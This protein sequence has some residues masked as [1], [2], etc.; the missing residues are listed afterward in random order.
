M[1]PTPTESTASERRRSSKRY[2][3]RHNLM[4]G[5][6]S[7]MTT[8]SSSRTSTPAR[9]RN[10]TPHRNRRGRRSAASLVSPV[11]IHLDTQLVLQSPSLIHNSPPP[12]YE[13][14]PDSPFRMI[15]QQVEQPTQGCSIFTKLFFYRLFTNSAV[16]R[17]NFCFRTRSSDTYD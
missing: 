17:L 11:P 3:G 16:I 7:A 5:S 8:P 15:I 9:S 4:A 1:P 14:F 10:A 6:D 2:T 12:P 13:V